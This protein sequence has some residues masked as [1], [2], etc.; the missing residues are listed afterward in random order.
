MTLPSLI[1]D[2]AHS[3]V[4]GFDV[5]PRREIVLKLSVLRWDGSKGTFLSGVRVR[6]GG[7]KNFDEASAFFGNARHQRSELS[8]LRYAV[9]PP[10]KPGHLNI[11]IA[12]ERVDASIVVQCSSVSVSGPKPSKSG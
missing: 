6:F 11:E 8:C 5:G 9:D 2:F 1:C 12:L 4:E 7:I 10:S 3:L